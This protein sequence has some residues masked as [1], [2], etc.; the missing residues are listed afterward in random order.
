M[1]D[2]LAEEPD[3]SWGGLVIR[4]NNGATSP[5]VPPNKIVRPAKQ[6]ALRKVPNVVAPQK[7]TAVVANTRKELPVVATTARHQQLLG[8]IPQRPAKRSK[9]VVP[10]PPASQPP[11]PKGLG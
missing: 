9:A 10:Q 8:T 7:E 4:R 1:A 5:M 3:S 6:T 11:P 2:E